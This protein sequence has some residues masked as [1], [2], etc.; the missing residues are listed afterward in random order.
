M[1]AR[2][3]LPWALLLG[4]SSAPPAARPSPL[5]SGPGVYTLRYNPAACLSHVPEAQF[6]LRLTPPRV[7]LGWERVYLE[8][9]AEGEVIKALNAAARRAP[10]ALHRVQGDLRERAVSLAGGHSG[11]ALIIEALS[12]DAPPP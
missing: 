1:R 6:E 12:V 11:R 4:C 10:E 9:E 3:W 8:D 5:P 7:G 2:R